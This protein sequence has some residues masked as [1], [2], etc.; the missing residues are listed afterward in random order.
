MQRTEVKEEAYNIWR[1]GET[2][3]GAVVRAT[4]RG[5]RKRLVTDTKK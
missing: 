4:V 5:E 2:G 1:V 3:L